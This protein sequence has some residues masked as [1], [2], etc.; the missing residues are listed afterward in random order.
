MKV[1]NL[2]AS[3][4]EKVTW[5]IKTVSNVWNTKW[6]QVGIFFIILKIFFFL[7]ITTSEC[8]NSE[9]TQILFDGLSLG[10]IIPKKRLFIWIL[11]QE[12]KEPDTAGYSFLWQRTATALPSFC[13][14]QHKL[15]YLKSHSFL[16]L[17]WT[18]FHQQS[19]SGGKNYFIS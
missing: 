2:H 11:H 12:K 4:T 13:L 9:G 3:T 19:S 10:Y 5:D 18:C 8:T 17:Q 15:L 7:I 14:W 1:Y 6:N 16:W